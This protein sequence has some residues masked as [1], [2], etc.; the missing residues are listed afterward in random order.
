MDIGFVGNLN[1]GRALQLEP[2]G[3]EN[4]IEHQD[5][6]PAAWAGIDHLRPGL[7]VIWIPLDPFSL[8]FSHSSPQLSDHPVSQT[9]PGSIPM[10][11]IGS[12]E[13]VI[14]NSLKSCGAAICRPCTAGMMS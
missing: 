4:T 10:T 7:V 12:A 1:F 13:R 2:S 6:S 9:G 5:T 8:T 14:R 11:S 3:K